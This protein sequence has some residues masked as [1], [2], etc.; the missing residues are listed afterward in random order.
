MKP[1]EHQR[2]SGSAFVEAAVVTPL[3]IM[4]VVSIMQ[5]GYIF[6]VMANLRGAS[7]VAA[8]AAI[9]GTG[10]THLDVCN[11]A[12]NS[13]ASIIDATQLSCQTSPAVLPAAANS[14]VTI[15]LSYPVPIL[16]SQAGVLKGP[17]ITLSARTT[18]Q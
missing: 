6:G 16:A 2:E 10:N 8:R 3:L 1:R 11:A 15:T 17:T 9:L 5:F 13:I 7:A 12:R 4:L 14:P 18:M